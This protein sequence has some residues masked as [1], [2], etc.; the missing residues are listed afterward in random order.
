M[1]R[2]LGLR[3][4]PNATHDHSKLQIVVMGEVTDTALSRLQALPREATV[5]AT[6][7][8][9]SKIANPGVVLNAN[10]LLCS[11]G[12]AQTLA[13]LL[14]SMPRLEWVHSLFAGI[15]HLKCTEFSQNPQFVVTN[16]KGVFSSSLAEYVF[17]S[18][19]YFNK[20]IPR[21]IQQKKERKWDRYTIGE[22]RG[23]TMGIVG[24]GDIGRACAHLG[25]AYGM[26]VLGLRKNPQLSVNDSL[27][28]KVK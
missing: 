5:V 16:A 4:Y 7:T 17:A 28:D 26:R 13:P 10:V 1:L 11:S 20:D 23:Q 18:I 9:L 27:L 12:N 19:A 3:A 21:L 8:H 22:I 2:W 24:Y 15:D 14:Q 6:C 25:K